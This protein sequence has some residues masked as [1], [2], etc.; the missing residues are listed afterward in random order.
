MSAGYL[1]AFE[2]ID[3]SGKSTA[4]RAVAARLRSEGYTVDVTREP[5]GTPLGTQIRE[6]IMASAETI[7]PD[8]EL[9][10]M[11][12]DRAEHLA[13]LIE[14]A[15]AEGHI[16]ITDRY[17]AS[18]IAY[19]GYGHGIDLARVQA[20]LDLATNGRWPDLTLL[21]DIPVATADQRRRRNLAAMDA[22]DRRAGE[23][24]ERVRTGYLVQANDN[25]DWVTIDATTAP[26]P[27]A[28]AC[29]TAIRDRLLAGVT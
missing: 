4:V 14:P 15:L 21:L 17:A 24:R 18:T 1:I 10:L 13:K 27:V 3:G 22:L 11:C 29:Y 2:G 28:D 26:G 19:Q 9:L 20:A 23:F 25:P 12:A 8:A 6:L 16:V 5:G 7:A